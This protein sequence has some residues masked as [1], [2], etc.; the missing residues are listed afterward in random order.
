GNWTDTS[1]NYGNPST[2]FA[3][4]GTHSYRLTIA[5]GSG[6][7]TN[8]ATMT[9]NK[10]LVPNAGTVMSFKTRTR[11]FGGQLGDV[12]VSTDSGGTWESVYSQTSDDTSFVQRSVSL[13]KYA[14]K[15]INIRFT[16]AYDFNGD[17]VTITDP[18]GWYVDD[19]AIGN[20]QSLGTT[21]TSGI[22]GTTGFSFTPTQSAEY[23]MQVRANFP[24]SGFGAWSA[25]KRV[26]TYPTTAVAQAL[27]AP[28]FTWTTTGSPAWSGETSVTN[29]GVDALRSGAIGNNAT[30]S[31]ETTVVGVTKLKFW[32]KSD[33]E[34]GDFLR[35][36]VDGVEPFSGISGDHDWEKKTISL[37]A[38]PHSV[39]WTFSRDG[40]G[41][42]G[43]NAAYVDQVT[44]GAK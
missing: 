10:T 22:L 41:S 44:T 3:A 12:E 15:A 17:G 23:D 6:L 33:S 5:D 40:S 2:D 29:D 8:P 27:D 13:A 25:S 35:V 30:T 9:L 18:E 38:G 24:G 43:A 36:T 20:V 26:S 31:F 21:T 32:W 4:S 28:Q 42:A 19:I 7:E 16:V 1:H 37:T 39:R 14:K 11:Y 34:A